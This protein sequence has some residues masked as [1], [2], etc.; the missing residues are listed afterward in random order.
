MTR[1]AYAL[2]KTIQCQMSQYWL[3]NLLS[4][5]DGIHIVCDADS[6]LTCDLNG[7]AEQE[8]VQ[9]VDMDGSGSLEFPEFKIVRLP[10]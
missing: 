9:A 6:T 8:A 2:K 7:P 3:Q 1:A 10:H 5:W 4:L